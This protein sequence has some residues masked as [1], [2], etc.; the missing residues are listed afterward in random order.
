M[1]DYLRFIRK[2]KE[3]KNI[4]RNVPL[5]RN[6]MPILEEWMKHN[7]YDLEISPDIWTDI[8]L[9]CRWFVHHPSPGLYIRQ[10]PIQVHTKF[11]EENS[12]LLTSL[13]DFL[14]P[15]EHID[16]AQRDFAR[17]FHLN[18]DE[19]LNRCRFRNKDRD[20]D[21]SRPV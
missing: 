14:L 6:K 7:P 10:I 18:W 21:I 5:I 1:E 13:L 8:L 2:S 16:S 15:A 9:V 4:S 19:P 12:I 20:D 3:F 17:R 11:I